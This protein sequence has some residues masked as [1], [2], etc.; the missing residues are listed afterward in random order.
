MPGLISFRQEFA[1]TAP[2]APL[3]M[4]AAPREP[5]VALL[6][7]YT[8][9]H[10][11]PLE[12]FYVDDASSMAGTTTRFSRDELAGC[13]RAAERELQ[14]VARVEAAEASAGAEAAAA[15]ARRRAAQ[16]R[17]GVQRHLVAS[18][19]AATGA[20]AAAGLDVLVFGATEPWLECLCV[21]SNRDPNPNSDPNPPT[22]TLPGGL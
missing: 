12:R 16:H 4:A 14:L 13:V 1:N 15:G 2:V 17:G 11:V 20:A 6:G 22:L 21:A 19:L 8:L 7:A 5:P 9:Q 3:P 18:A 10:Q